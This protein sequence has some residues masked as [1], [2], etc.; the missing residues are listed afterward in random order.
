MYLS[1]CLDSILSQA[2]IN[3]EIILVNSNSTDGS[4]EICSD[5]DARFDNIRYFI[6]EGKPVMWQGHRLGMEKASGE[7]IW[8]VD[9]DDLLADCVLKVVLKN[10]NEFKPDVL[11]GRFKT[12]LEGNISNFSDISYEEKYVNDCSKDDALIYLV[13]KQQPVLPTWRLIFSAALYKNVLRNE[14]FYQLM[15]NAHQD[16]GFNALILTSAKSIRYT[17]NILYNYRVRDN[18]ISRTDPSEK[19]LAYCKALLVLSRVISVAAKTE[20][21]RNFGYVYYKQF[22]FLLSTIVGM[23]EVYWNQNICND[24]DDF[25]KAIDTKLNEAHE[26]DFTFIVSLISHGTSAALSCL[27]DDCLAKITQIAVLAKSKGKSVYLAPAG[28]VGIFLKSALEQ[29]GLSISGFFDED[30]AKEG[31]EIAGIMVYYP[32]NT[33]EIIKNKQVTIL[34]GAS[35]ASVPK[36]MKQNFISLGLSESDLI[37]IE[38]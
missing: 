15:C 10:L 36:K 31:M 9:G 22:L 28:N 4:G 5:Y 35:Y 8:F 34:I 30:K 23:S 12:F 2:E 3:Y 17:S 18:S 26:K 16:T 21:E 29:Q 33:V 19:I 38:L 24:I 37:I 13:D 25:I 1:D 7:Y 20:A 6:I 11:F 14:K 32:T 27:K